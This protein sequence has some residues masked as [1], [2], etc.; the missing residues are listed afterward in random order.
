MGIKVQTILIKIGFNFFSDE[1]SGQLSVSTD[2]VFAFPNPQSALAGYCYVS[3]SNSRVVGLL[4]SYC[5]NMSFLLSPV[6]NSVFAYPTQQTVS[7]QVLVKTAH[8][9]SA[10][11][12]VQPIQW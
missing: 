8:I 9:Q 4:E 2:S 12:L 10:L 5:E 1:T 7:S 11:R 6:T 3:G